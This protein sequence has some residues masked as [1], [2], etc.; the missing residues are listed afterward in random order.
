MCGGGAHLPLP[1][2]EGNFGEW[3]SPSILW[4]AGV[5][6]RASGLVA[7]AFTAGTTC[8]P[9]GHTEPSDASTVEGKRVTGLESLCWHV[10]LDFTPPF[11]HKNSPHLCN[12][13]VFTW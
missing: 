11:F 2:S 7:S 13:S 8:Q 3:F 9:L 4:D 6:P 10:S 1:A 5:E 12:L